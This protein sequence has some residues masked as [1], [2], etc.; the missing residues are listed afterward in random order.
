MMKLFRYGTRGNEKPGML[1]SQGN[2]RDLSNVVADIDAALLSSGLSAL[3]SVNP[4][5]LPQLERVERFAEPVRD[6]GKFL[7]IGLNYSD[8]AAEANMA[9][10]AEPVV[11][12]KA[13]SAIIGPNDDVLLPPGSIKS[14]WEVELGVFIGREARYIAADENP[15]DYVAGVCVVNDLSEREYQ[16]E[17]GGQWDKGKGCDTFGPVGPYLVTL[18][19]AGDLSSLNLWLEVNGTRRQSGSTSKLIFD[20]PY[21]VRYLSQFMSLQPGD[22]ISTGTPSGVGMGMKPPRYLTEGDQIRAGIHG[23]GEQR[24]LVKRYS[25]DR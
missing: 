12:M 5:L 9:V 22:L 14:D 24:Q 7:C 3:Q 2:P 4:D 23:L 16:L 8:H 17:R 25:I 1:D 20:V 21:L 11:F 10:P 15:L 13:T 19:E 18:D 6:V